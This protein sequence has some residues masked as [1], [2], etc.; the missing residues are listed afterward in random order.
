MGGRA[1]SGAGAALWVNVQNTDTGRSLVRT[2]IEFEP[3]TQLGLGRGRG[4]SE[5]FTLGRDTRNNSCPQRKD[6]VGAV[7]LPTKGAREEMRVTYE[8]GSELIR[9]RCLQNLFPVTIEPTFISEI[10]TFCVNQNPYSLSK[11]ITKIQ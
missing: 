2:A 11:Y 6:D 9:F 8:S 10:Q 1:E 3:G 4:E 5:T 7:A